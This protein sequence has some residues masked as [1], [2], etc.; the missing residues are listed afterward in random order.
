MTTPDLAVPPVTAAGGEPDLYRE[1]WNRLRRDIINQHDW[2]FRTLSQ[3]HATND[4]P[5]IQQACIQLANF[6]GVLGLMDGLVVS[7]AAPKETPG[8]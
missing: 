4:W 7:A 8:E 1:R 6:A 3:S 5:M 2:A